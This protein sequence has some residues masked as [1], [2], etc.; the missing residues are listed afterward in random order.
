MP[1]TCALGVSAACGEHWDAAEAHFAQAAREAAEM[2]FVVMQDEVRRWHAW[3]LLARRA[4]GDVERERTLLGEAVS[5][6]RALALP[7][8]TLIYEALLLRQAEV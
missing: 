3:M 2:R 8:R 1:F 5:H 7:R 6:A 4:S